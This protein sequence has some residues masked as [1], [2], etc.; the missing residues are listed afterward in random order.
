MFVFVVRRMVVSVFTLIVATAL[1][2]A[3]VAISGD[4]REDLYEDQSPNKAQKIAAR[5]QALHLD[6]SIPQRYA[7]WAGGVAK[8]VV[9]GQDCD[10]GKTVG[11]QDVAPLLTQAAGTTIK[12][13]ITATLLAMLLGVSVGIA[14]ALRQYSGF[15]YTITFGAFLFYSLP[16]FWVAVLLK[17]YLGIRFNDWLA[18]PTI[19]P[20]VAVVLAVLAGLALSG[21]VGGD[22]RRRAATAVIAGV[23]TLGVLL[24]LSWAEW[25]R[26]PALQ[27]PLVILLTVACA[28][29]ITYLVAGLKRRGVL[30]AALST[31]GVVA[32]AEFALVAV[33][34]DPTWVVV[35]LVTLGLIGV[36]IGAGWVFG[37]L[38]RGQAARAGA[39]TGLA[40]MVW[41][42]T[43]RMLNAVPDYSEAVNGRLVATIGS[44]TPNFEG[45]FWQR[46]LDSA[47]HLLLPT[48]SIMLISF[49]TYSR[50]TRATMLEV[51]H[52]DF[53]RTARAKGLTERTVV[54]RHAFRNALIPVATLAAYDFGAVISGAVISENV[55]GW[56]GMGSL[57]VGALKT[58]D[59]N[60]VMAFFIVTALSIV[61]FNMLADIAYAYLDPRVRLS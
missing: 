41:M 9:P 25:F 37:G 52:A 6:E 57:F 23:A 1:V 40:G 12:L 18:N 8:C 55:F 56:Q 59:P 51:M 10:L 38:D 19:A 21:L 47:S 53:V 29:G 48:L 20:G 44:N 35:A 30:Y 42:M 17:Q 61:V 26:Y 2:F 7:R 11:G 49:A 3:L 31:A 46:L 14:S 4:P 60:P 32:V 27:P 43:D 28:V 54:I 13:V 16:I 36:G 50:F 34:E 5:T 22:R 15:D 45:D 39:L 58:T 24:Y 33:L